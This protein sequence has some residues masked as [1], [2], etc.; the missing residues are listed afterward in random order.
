MTFPPKAHDAK[1]ACVFCH[2]TDL[3][4]EHIWG[5]WT[6]AVVPPDDQVVQRRKRTFSAVG[7][8]NGPTNRVVHPSKLVAGNLRRRRAK[9]VCTA[10][11]SGWMS[12]VEER[13]K[14]AISLVLTSTD[15]LWSIQDLRLI[16][17]WIEKTAM[18]HEADN[19]KGSA[20][21]WM[22]YRLRAT[23]AASPE[24]RIWVAK[25]DDPWWSAGTIARS[26]A[27]GSNV[28]AGLSVT[29]MSLGPL[30]FTI[31]TPYGPH[32]IPG[33]IV[34][35]PAGAGM[36]RIWP[37]LD[38]LRTAGLPVLTDEELRSLW[39]SLA[40]ALDNWPIW[41]SNHPLGIKPVSLGVTEP[42]F[43]PADVLTPSGRSRLTNS[44]RPV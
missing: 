23:L 41:K 20:P 39:T 36:R 14:G 31:I 21:P 4:R 40:H 10:C 16:A 42:P 5:Q 24:S 9:V 22:R 27:F 13:V 8:S 29:T 35:L 32:G 44:K 34:A 7:G 25:T 18:V 1:R 30:V 38:T 26:F 6:W 2:G 19:R 43:A 28:R 12:N 33:N 17:L 37:A 15:L 11:N 3:S